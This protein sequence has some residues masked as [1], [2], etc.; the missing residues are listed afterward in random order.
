MGSLLIKH[1]M[2]SVCLLTAQQELRGLV[3]STLESSGG[4]TCLMLSW[5]VYVRSEG[6]RNAELAAHLWLF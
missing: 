2:Q 3:S 1:D 4:R 5:T 6:S